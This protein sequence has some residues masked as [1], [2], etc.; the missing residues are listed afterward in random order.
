MNIKAF[1]KRELVHWLIISVPIIYLIIIYPKLPAII[2]THFNDGTPDDYSHKTSL[3]FLVPIIPIGFYVLMLVASIFDPKYNRPEF[4]GFMKSLRM[5]LTVITSAVALFLVYPTQSPADLK[6]G[7]ILILIIIGLMYT[8]LGNYLASIPP[9][10]F[11]GILTPWTL[12]DV[13]VWQKT[14]RLFGRSLFCIGLLN[15]LIY[16]FSSPNEYIIILFLIVLP[17]LL[18]ITALLYSYFLFRKLHPK[19][20]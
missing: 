9:N 4:S 7:S 3:L 17:I 12:K 13:T 2:P 20:Q 15:M 8:F 18:I 16:L 6:M 1:F 14:H 11:I 5:L 19:K 10:S